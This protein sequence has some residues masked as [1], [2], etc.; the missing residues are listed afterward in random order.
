MP[1]TVIIAV[2]GFLQCS[3]PEGIAKTRKYYYN[4]TDSAGNRLM[5]ENTYDS[6]Y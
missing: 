1:R 4:G 3:R 6:D 5:G 2:R